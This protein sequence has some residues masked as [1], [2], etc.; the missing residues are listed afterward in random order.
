MHK[1]ALLLLIVLAYSIPTNFDLRVQ[2]QRVKYTNYDLQT[3]GI[4]AG[5]AWAK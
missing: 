1:I 3:E 5:Y 2:T 4:C